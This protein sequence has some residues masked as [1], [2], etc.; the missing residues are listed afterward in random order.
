MGRITNNPEAKSPGRS[1]THDIK[2]DSD[3][4]KVKV[5]R[6]SHLHEDPGTEPPNKTYTVKCK[7]L[8]GKTRDGEFCNADT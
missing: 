7:Q 6:R 5:A 1:K 8:F 2:R 3:Y 4:P